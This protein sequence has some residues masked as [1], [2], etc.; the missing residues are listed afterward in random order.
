MTFADDIA[1]A[2]DAAGWPKASAAKRGRN[3]RWPYVPIL[4]YGVLRP[5]SPTTQIKRRAFATRP[6]AVADAQAWIDRARARLAADLA[7]PNL[8]A[9]REYHGL[10]RELPTTP[11]ETP[12]P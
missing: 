8:R 5:L 9:L 7:R 1:A 4:D 11:K 3:P 6:E 2:V 10:P 12:A